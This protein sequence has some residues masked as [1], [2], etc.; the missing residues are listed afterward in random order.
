M[1]AELSH[2]RGGADGYMCSEDLKGSNM[3]KYWSLEEMDQFM[4]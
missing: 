2:S 3:R 4:V 1:S